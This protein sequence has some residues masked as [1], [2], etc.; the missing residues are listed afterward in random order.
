[1]V[2]LRVVELE[3]VDEA[4]QHALGD[5]ADA[6]ALQP[7]VVLDA[8]ARQHGDLLAPQA[9]D[10]AVGA[11]V[12]GQARLGGVILARRVV[13]NSRMSSLAAMAP[14]VRRTPW[15][16]SPCRYPSQQCLWRGSAARLSGPRDTSTHAIRTCRTRLRRPRRP[17]MSSSAIK[18]LL[19]ISEP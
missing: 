5:A 9:G 8:D 2:A 12:H 15:W 6:A 17:G 18:S 3:G 7:R 13:R 19:T 11:A 16:G 1:M 14:T 4:V 10:A